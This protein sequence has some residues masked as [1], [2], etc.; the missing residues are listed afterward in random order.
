M[1]FYARQA[2][3]LEQRFEPRIHLTIRD[4]MNTLGYTSTSA[5]LYAI[6]N[7]VRYGFIEEEWHGEVKKYYLKSN[8]SRKDLQNGTYP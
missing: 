5:A 1:D 7:L 6:H 4:V 3:K 8:E 2:E